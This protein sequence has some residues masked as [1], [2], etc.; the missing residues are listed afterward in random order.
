MHITKRFFF[1]LLLSYSKWGNSFV[2]EI[3]ANLSKLYTRRF[4]GRRMM[5]LQSHDFFLF[6][7]SPRSLKKRIPFYIYLTEIVK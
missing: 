1:I 4:D 6:S 7:L 2:V 3:A 5:S